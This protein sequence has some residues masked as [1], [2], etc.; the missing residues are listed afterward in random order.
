V[1]LLIRVALLGAASGA[2]SMTGL[3]ALALS[4]PAPVGGLSR[5]GAVRY[6]VATGALAELAAD[7]LPRAPSRLAPAGL[8][9]RIAT[10]AAAGAIAARRTPEPGQAGG[11]RDPGGPAGAELA[12]SAALAAGCA[13]AAAWLGT[14]WRAAAA[15]RLGHDYIGAVLEDGAAVSAAWAASRG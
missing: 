1:K 2:R 14:R 5:G 8:G 12:A 4:A 13:V 10:G 11:R 15:R 6:L 3:A 9:I 7:K